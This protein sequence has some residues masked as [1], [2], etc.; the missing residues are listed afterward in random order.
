MGKKGLRKGLSEPLPK[1]FFQIDVNKDLGFKVKA[2]DL[3]FKAKDLSFKAKD[4]IQHKAKDLSFKAN[5]FSFYKGQG[6]KIWSLKT[7]K[8]KIWI[9]RPNDCLNN[10]R[11]K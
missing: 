5:D 11:I 2:T 4:L 9:S 7:S 6:H 10:S 1:D 8:I 3:N